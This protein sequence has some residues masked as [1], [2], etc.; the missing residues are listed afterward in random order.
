[1]SS[2][3]FDFTEYSHRRFNPLTKGWV[4]VSPHRLKRPWQG[5][6]EEISSESKPEYD[7]KCYLC[8][9]NVR[10]GGHETNEN[11]ESTFVF[12]ND[13][14]AVLPEQ[15]DYIEEDKGSLES[16]FFHTKGI[17]G[18]CYVICFSP[19]HNLT[20]PVMAH[21]D[22]VGIVK[23]WQK[24]YVDLSKTAAKYV[25]IF[26]N[27]GSVMGCSNPHP[28]GQAW[29]LTDVP[30]EVQRELES[31]GEYYGQ[32]HSHMLGDYVKLELAKRE[33]L[34]AENDSFVVVVPYWAVWPFETMVLSKKH[35]KSI[36]EFD[37][38]QVEDLASIVKVLT[39][40][41]DNL[42]RTSFPYSMGLH[43]SPFE[44]VE[45]SWFHMHFYPPLLRSATVK[46]FLVGFE[47][48]GEPQRD[49]TPEQA[50]KRLRDLSEVHYLD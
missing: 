19:K 47:M 45:T 30:Y 8:P 22:I 25:Q 32:H 49:L 28:H 27:K 39:T 48:L 4:L 20:I 42:F 9:S 11:Y 10:A 31:M 6:E 29:S 41:Y 26:E 7:P 24:L 15:P 35:L 21:Q 34:V 3:Q 5:L 37:S 44:K 14:S 12:K 36:Q 23:A 38:K 2:A 1:M 18:Q 17:K 50:A 46:K 16:R 40:K 33:R 43:Q 13:F